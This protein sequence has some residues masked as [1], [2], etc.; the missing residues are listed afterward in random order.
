MFHLIDR[1]ERL[2]DN[3]QSLALAAVSMVFCAI[4]MLCVPGVHA[5]PTTGAVTLVGSNNATVTMTGAGTVCWFEWGILEG[6]GMTWNT[7]NKTPAAGVCTATIKGSPLSGNQ[8]FYYRACDNTGCGADS[9]FT[10]AVVTALP[11]LTYGSTF[12]NITENNFDITMIGGS[13]MAP[14]MWLVPSFPALVWGLIFGFLVFG[15]W[16]RTRDSGY[17]A[18]YGFML[19]VLLFNPIYGLG[20]I[21][22]A[23]FAAI[24]QGIFYA[25]VAGVL[26]SLIKK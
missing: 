1:Y 7:P 17:S 15:I 3:Q 19:A 23:E 4:V 22:P 6:S 25:A 5:L 24:G 13:V 12:E 21:I 8:K 20:V 11:T 18:V 9:S 10:T 16:L 2:S 26:L 14:Y